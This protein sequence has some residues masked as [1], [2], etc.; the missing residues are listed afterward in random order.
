M[1]KLYYVQADNVLI[2]QMLVQG[3]NVI[4]RD[5]RAQIR[6]DSHSV[7]SLHA[8][9]VLAQQ[10]LTLTD[11]KSTNGTRINGK[12]VQTHILR[13]GDVI[14]LGTERLVYF[15]TETLGDPLNPSKVE[16]TLDD[17]RSKRVNTSNEEFAEQATPPAANASPESLPE[18]REKERLDLIPGE[19]TA[20]ITL[21]SGARSG[22]RFPLQK[23]STTLGQPGK[24][25]FL[26]VKKNGRY[27]VL[28][29]ENSAPPFVNGNPIPSTGQYLSTGD[30]IELAGARVQFEQRYHA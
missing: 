10:Q 14:T 17:G 23:P 4:G 26:I 6:I 19:A 24:Q 22:V 28:V 2:E 11:L 9:L 27:Q 12:R 29:G 8:K 3:E 1:T 15:N 18:R 5:K 20:F 7:S 13:H 21:L 30:V 16:N 25:V